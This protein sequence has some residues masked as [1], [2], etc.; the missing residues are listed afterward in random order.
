MELQQKIDASLAFLQSQNIENADIA[1][2]LGTGLSGLEDI[3][4]DKTIVPYK[5]IPHFPVSTVEGHKGRLIFGTF[6]GKKIVLLSG[7][8]H[9]YEGYSMSEV[10]YYIHVVKA[11]GI[12]QLIITNAAGGLNPHYT[13]GDLVVVKD[14][15]NM[16]PI[17]PLR[18]I[19]D[20]GLG[21]MFPDMMRAYDVSLR[22]KLKE[23]A[24]NTGIAIR[25]GVYLG[26]QGPSLETPAEYKMARNFGADV[27]GMSSIPEVIVARYR[28]IPVLMISVSS[29]ACYPQSIIKE[30]TLDEVIDVMNKSGSKLKELLTDYLKK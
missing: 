30:T 3:L 2:V 9:F 25:E 28:S 11:L 8:F 21:D 27:L 15:I 18:E 5:D 4:L 6:E 23:S 29:N 20:S 24:K 14:H 7:R 1:V 13:V 17:N 22:Q 26:W 10:T 16:F 19:S 12:G